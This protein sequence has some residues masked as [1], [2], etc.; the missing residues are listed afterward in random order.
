M[1][2]VDSLQSD[3]E[4]FSGR[5]RLYAV[6]GLAVVNHRREAIIIKLVSPLLALSQRKPT[7]TFAPQQ[8][9]CHK[10]G[11][12]SQTL[13]LYLVLGS[14]A[15]LGPKS[16]AHA[17]QPPVGLFKSG[18]TCGAQPGLDLS[19]LPHLQSKLRLG[20]SPPWRTCDPFRQ[21]GYGS[22][23]PTHGPRLQSSL[24]LIS[25]C[26]LLPGTYISPCTMAAAVPIF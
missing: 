22:V 6:V 26:V 15:W 18:P 13:G 20:H 14:Q 10:E 25:A 21:P 5:R 19:R 3:E 7:N 1:D 24:Q 9:C 17:N 8:G 12:L 4:D 23:Q 11:L 16:C 2:L